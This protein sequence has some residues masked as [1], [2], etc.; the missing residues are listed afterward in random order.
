M[1]DQKIR[2]TIYNLQR[3]RKA[4]ERDYM[5]KIYKKNSSMQ[6]TLVLLFMCMFLQ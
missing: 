2:G 3:E 5:K 6:I 1:T 4:L